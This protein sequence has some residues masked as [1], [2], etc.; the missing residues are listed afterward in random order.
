MG[1]QQS[2]KRG[3]RSAAQKE[4][5]A[6]DAY[7][8]IPATTDVGGA[9]GNRKRDMPSDVSSRFEANRRGGTKHKGNASSRKAAKGLESSRQDGRP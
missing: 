2:Q 6:R 7:A 1:E 9:F 4:D 5:S 3:L 8:P